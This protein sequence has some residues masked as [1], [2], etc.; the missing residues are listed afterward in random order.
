MT[1]PDPYFQNLAAAA[2]TIVIHTSPQISA[3]R[4][5][6]AITAGL[7]ALVLGLLVLLVIGIETGPV[8]FM[9][10]TVTATIPAPLYV[11]LVLWTRRGSQPGHERKSTRLDSS[12]AE[13]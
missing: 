12:H 4:L 1:T 2:P 8:A 9:L 10:G 11:V 13:R 6:L 7:I 3:I 5:V